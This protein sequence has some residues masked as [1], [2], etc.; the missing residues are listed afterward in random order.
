MQGRTID[1]SFR[2]DWMFLAQ[3]LIILQQGLEDMDVLRL[4]DGEWVRSAYLDDI[5]KYI[6]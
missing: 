5:K 1:N 4:G 3:A 6:R 2:G